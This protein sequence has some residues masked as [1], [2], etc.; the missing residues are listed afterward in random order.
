[1]SCCSLRSARRWLIALLAWLQVAGAS[2]TT[3][4]PSADVAPSAVAVPVPS[5]HLGLQRN[6]RASWAARDAVM[7]R[8]AL[9]GRRPPGAFLLPPQWRQVELRSSLIAY[10]IGATSR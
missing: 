3:T 10:E 9:R 1:M 2:R 7:T 5:S 6:R 8:D 4:T